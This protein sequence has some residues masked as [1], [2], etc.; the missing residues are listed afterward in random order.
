ME[1]IKENSGNALVV[2]M[3]GRL[4]TNTAK[5]FEEQLAGEYEKY[6]EIILD[7]EKIQY[8]SSA[9]LRVLLSAQKKMNGKAMSLKNVSTNVMEVFEITGFVDILNII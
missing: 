7:F 4:D 9:G 5:Q 6:E 1:F 8:L 2:K 3:S